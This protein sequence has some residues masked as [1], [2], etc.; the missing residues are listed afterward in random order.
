MLRRANIVAIVAMGA[1]VIC[2]A[3][4]A[5]ARPSKIAASVR[6]EAGAMVDAPRGFV[7]M[8]ARDA[9]ACAPATPQAIANAVTDNIVTGAIRAT[10]RPE[11]P[12]AP[13][14]SIT[15]AL[16][17]PNK[18]FPLSL[19]FSVLFG[20]SINL[21]ID[22]ASRIA[23]FTPTAPLLQGPSRVSVV[24]D[25]SAAIP[26]AS[27]LAKLLSA[28]SP[29]VMPDLSAGAAL[30]EARA[31]DVLDAPER[32]TTLA[33]MRRIVS[34]INTTVNRRTIQITDRDR[35]GTDER[36]QRAGAE[37]GSA[38]DC[39]DIALEK[40]SQLL[41]AGIAPDRLLLA[42]VYTHEVGLHTVLVVRMPDRDVV[43]DSLKRGLHTR[44]TLNYSWIS[45]QSPDDPMR[46][47]RVV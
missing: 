5:S 27:S 23:A 7:E 41:D 28:R 36:W 26:T 16:V 18:D 42:I 4:A 6:I 44:R 38:G 32:T 45:I 11:A 17:L 20:A 46:W 29:M 25:P 37:K 40:R 31:A 35:F 34:R 47:L 10:A 22:A 9:A 19:R 14:A 33:A 1:G 30:A 12:L 8:C 15:P 24:D 39:E 43:L 21:P 2:A 3:S 13:S